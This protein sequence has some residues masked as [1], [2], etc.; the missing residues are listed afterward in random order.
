MRSVLFIFLRGVGVLYHVWGEKARAKR[1]ALASHLG[2]S[3]ITLRDIYNE[4][5]D[6]KRCGLAVASQ[7]DTKPQSDVPADVLENL[8]KL[9]L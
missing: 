3:G 5:Q 6:L 4:I 9:G 7:D 1:E 8:G 2:Q